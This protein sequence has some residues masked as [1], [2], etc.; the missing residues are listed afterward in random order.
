M[1]YVLFNLLL[2]KETEEKKMFYLG[3]CPKQ[4]TPPIHS[5]RLGLPNAQ[6]DP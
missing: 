3:L 5:A 6:N 4:R 1:F 2:L